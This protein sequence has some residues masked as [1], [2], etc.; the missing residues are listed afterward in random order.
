MEHDEMESVLHFG[1]RAL[2]RDLSRPNTS[3][4]NKSDHYFE[5]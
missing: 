2:C 5:T 1:L 3:L 4:P